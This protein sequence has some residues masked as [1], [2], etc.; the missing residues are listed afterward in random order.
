M[1]QAAFLLDGMTVELIGDGKH[2][3]RELMQMTVK[4]KG[5]DKTI[6]VTDAMRAAGT[7]R[8]KAILVQN[9]PTTGLS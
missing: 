9:T 3:P 1:I 4:L 8:E 7:G 2:I 6:L 5:A